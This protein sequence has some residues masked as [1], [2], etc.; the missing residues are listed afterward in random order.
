[1]FLRIHLNIHEH[2]PVLVLKTS[3]HRRIQLFTMVNMN[4]D[5]TV[6]LGKLDEIRQ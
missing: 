6:S 4:A 1:M 3:F 5:M 2:Q